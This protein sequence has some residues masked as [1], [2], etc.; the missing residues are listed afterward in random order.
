MIYVLEILD[1]KFVKVG[2]ADNV[3]SRI[4]QLQT[5]NPFEVK[6]IFAIEGTLKQEQAL[7]GALQ[8][9][10]AR[11]R[12][13]MPPNEW[14]PGLNPFMTEFM[15]NLKYGFDFGLTYA[16]KYNSSVRQGSTKRDTDLKPN[17]KWPIKA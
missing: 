1:K 17:I 7:H 13:P 5:G 11:I 4:A 12:I 10:F 2:F 9:A 3:E 8:K 6:K 15:E 16:E 14:Y